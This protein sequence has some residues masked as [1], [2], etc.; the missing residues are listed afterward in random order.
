MDFFNLKLEA[1]ARAIRDEA[2]SYYKAGIDLGYHKL[3]KYYLLTEQSPVYRAAIILH[4]A[5]NE[6]YFEHKWLKWP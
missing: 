5:Q 1:Q 4:P 3:Q 2:E 6:S